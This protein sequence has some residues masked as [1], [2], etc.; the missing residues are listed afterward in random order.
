[1]HKSFD[2]GFDVNPFRF[3]PVKL[4]KILLSR[5]PDVKLSSKFYGLSSSHS[6][7]EL[8]HLHI[9]DHRIIDYASFPIFIVWRWN[10]RN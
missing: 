1:M 2:I 9:I 7:N 5:T 4:F 10:G 8:I 6:F 3:V